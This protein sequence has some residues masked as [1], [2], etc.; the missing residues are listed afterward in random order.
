MRDNDYV[1]ARNHPNFTASERPCP[2]EMRPAHLP[3]VGFYRGLLSGIELCS[4]I[5]GRISPGH[6]ESCAVRL[7]CNQ[8][9]PN[10]FFGLTMVSIDNK[11]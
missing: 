7:P 4:P 2:V 5:E 9:A 6:R 11:F 10:F 8:D 3:K 1:K